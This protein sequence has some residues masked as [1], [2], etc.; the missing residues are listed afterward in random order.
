M[1]LKEYSE[2]AAVSTPAKRAYLDDCCE[3]M[4]VS[5]R[6]QMSLQDP[7]CDPEKSRQPT[8]ATIFDLVHTTGL[9]F[10]LLTRMRVVSQPCRSA[11]CIF[12]ESRPSE[13]GFLVLLPTDHTMGK[14]TSPTQRFQEAARLNIV[15]TL[16]HLHCF[17]AWQIVLSVAS[18][19]C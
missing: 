2:D 13:V 18:L 11:S 17:P 6:Q 7:A 19:T 16:Q 4:L 5:S 3:T 1:K 14:T 12:S 10:T 15:T 9:L 8:L